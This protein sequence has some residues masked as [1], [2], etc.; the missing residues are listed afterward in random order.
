[1]YFYGPGV[2]KG[3]TIP[4]A[5]TPDSAVMAAHL[6]KLPALRRHLDATVTLKNKG[7]TGTLLSNIFEGEPAEV[8]HPRYIE[9]YLNTGT[10][11]GSGT[12]YADYHAGMLE[13]LE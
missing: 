5:E 1:M 3:A 11:T 2:K 10:Y 8:S 9:K 13:L 4:Y 6:L 12:E 7:A